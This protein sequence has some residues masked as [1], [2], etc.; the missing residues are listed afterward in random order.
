MKAMVLPMNQNSL[1]KRTEFEFC[2]EKEDLF[3]VFSESSIDNDD[4]CEKQQDSS[5][6]SNILK[7]R[8]SG[9]EDSQEEKF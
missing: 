7:L 5:E 1:I 6:R 8:G 4:V 9:K 3:G 2:K